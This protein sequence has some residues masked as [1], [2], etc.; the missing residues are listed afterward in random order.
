MDRAAWWTTVPGGANSRTRLSNY[1]FHFLKKL[2]LR[3]RETV[4][5]ACSHTASERQ[6]R[7]QGPLP[8]VWSACPLQTC[9]GTTVAPIQGCV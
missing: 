4:R 6:K 5:S 7:M 1:H 9:P 3:P 8:A 2:K